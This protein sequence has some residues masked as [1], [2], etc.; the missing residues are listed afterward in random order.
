MEYRYESI[1]HQEN[2]P[3][4]IFTH[5]LD[6]YPYHWH[7]D[8]ELL[9]ILSGTCEM[10]TSEETSILKEGDLYLINRNEIHHTKATSTAEKTEI[11]VLQFDLNHY[12]RFF[13]DT[14]SLHF[15]IRCGDEGQTDSRILD[16][17]RRGLAQL[18]LAVTENRPTMPMKVEI[19]MLELLML[20]TTHFSDPIPTD[21]KSPQQDNRQ[22]EILKYID[23]HYMDAD[24]SLNQI[25]DAFFMNPQYLSRYF[26][27]KVGIPLKKFLDQMRLNKSLT[28]LHL[29]DDRVLD[30]ALRFGFPDAKAYYRVFKEVLGTT[31]QEY[32]SHHKIDRKSLQPM[33]YFSINSIDTHSKLLRYLDFADEDVEMLSTETAH[34]TIDLSKHTPFSNKACRLTTFGYAP[35]GL[36]SDFKK[37]LQRLQTEIGFDYLRFHGI[38]SDEL[39]VVSRLAD[40]TL[41]F[42]FT[43]IDALF[44]QF[45]SA[46]I[47]PFIELGFMPKA[48]A[49][50]PQTI[51]TYGANVSAP[52]DLTEWQSLIR[53][54]I[55]HLF[56]RYGREEVESWYFEFW[57]EPEIEGIFWADS[58]EQFFAFFEATYRCMK[59]ISP[60][61]KL[62]GFGTLFIESP[63]QWSAAFLA[64]ASEKGIALDFFSFHLYNIDFKITTDIAPLLLS[65]QSSADNAHLLESLDVEQLIRAAK[66]ALGDAGFM[67]RRIDEILTHPMTSATDAVWITEWNT[68]TN[69][70]ELLRDTCYTAPFIVKTV[71]ENM[72][73]LSGMGYWSFTDIFEEL[74]L[75]KTLFHGG[76]G[77]LTINGLRKPSFHAF[78]FLSQ[79]G[80]RLIFKDDGILVTGRS[81]EIQILLYHYQHYND[82]FASLDYSQIS[83]TNRHCVFS[84]ATEKFM[85]L[86][87]ENL[88]R[89]H[90]A[91]QNYDSSQ[92]GQYIIEHQYVNPSNG[93]IFDAWVKMGAPKA[94]ADKVTAALEAASQPGYYQEIK[95][96]ED[97]LTLTVK[98]LPHEIRLIKIRPYYAEK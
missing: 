61:L 9:L 38:F 75:P 32:R 77:L 54:F 60:R 39:H 90:S 51:F 47:K 89:I 62:G 95:S 11:L 6:H 3:I 37:Q 74:A 30:I 52:H 21:Q 20:L 10:R 65:H 12:A 56:N 43:H 68:S 44:D 26:K 31:P 13:P 2:L 40:G 81:D 97:N 96:V 29:T 35:H 14:K 72:D 66:V 45:L 4:K 18:M 84:E 36:R 86:T 55:H 15:T 85:T 73:K 42:N 94:I 67:T 59:A 79:L 5:T 80:D 41:F 92:S 23:A 87:L 50:K 46:G 69:G 27:L 16:R 33:D 53:H 57:N 78:A 22:L 76:F 88:T 24:L 83:E 93:S 34:V 70:R 7:E 58:K 19:H 71:L 28:A 25:A 64:Y 17:M 82:L 1:V 63:N 98:L 48:L 49:S 8:S 91:M